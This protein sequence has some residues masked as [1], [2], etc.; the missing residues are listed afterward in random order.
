MCVIN[1]IKLRRRKKKK[2]GN[3]RKKANDKE[4]GKK[5]KKN[6]EIGVITFCLFVTLLSSVFF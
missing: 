3:K 5:K 4:E 1:C 6:N 2:K